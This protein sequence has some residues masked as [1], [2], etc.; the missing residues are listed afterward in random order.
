MNLTDTADMA[1][2][3]ASA[4]VAGGASLSAGSGV[5]MYFSP[6]QWQVIGI[7]GGLVIGLLGLVVNAGINFYFR[8]KELKL[9]MAKLDFPEA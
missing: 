4:A 8:H 2:R 3:A 6:A 1:H 9:R 7:L 5:L